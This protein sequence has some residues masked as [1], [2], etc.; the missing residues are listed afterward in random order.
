MSGEPKFYD[1][2]S[3][4][5]VIGGTR[6]LDVKLA[7]RRAMNARKRRVRARKGKRR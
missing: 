6:F 7:R 1:V 4:E 2:E 5:L 3:I